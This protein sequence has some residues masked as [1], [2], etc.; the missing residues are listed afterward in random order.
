MEPDFPFTIQT[1]Q[2]D[3]TR[4]T[5]KYNPYGDD[6]IVDRIGV[7]KIVE[8]LVGVEEITV[9]QDIDIVKDC[10]EEWIDDRSKP[11]VDFDDEQQQS[12]EQDLTNL[13]ILE[14]LK[15]ILSDPEKTSA[16]IQDVD[17]ESMKTKKTKGMI[18]PGLPRKSNYSFLPP[19][20]VYYPVCNRRGRR[21][22]FLSG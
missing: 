19:T 17:R 12:C 11:A 15:E 13:R 18:L 3:R 2:S 9:S 8:E 22:I 16:T 14:C 7:K 10:N 20:L 5:N 1:R 21:W 6:F 4:L